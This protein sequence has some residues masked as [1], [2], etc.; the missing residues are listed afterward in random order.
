[1]L[2]SD[3]HTLTVC[4]TLQVF[5]A[6]LHGRFGPGAPAAVKIAGI[7]DGPDGVLPAGVRFSHE[8]YCLWLAAV[9]AR[10]ASASSNVVAMHGCL[11]APVVEGIPVPVG[12]LLEHCAGAAPPMHACMHAAHYVSLPVQSA[13]DHHLAFMPRLI[14]LSWRC[15][16]VSWTLKRR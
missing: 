6:W 16:D 13:C 7:H 10:V 14:C 1:M 5:T 3:G 2:R 9:A 11:F 15:A 4:G 12:I 8:A